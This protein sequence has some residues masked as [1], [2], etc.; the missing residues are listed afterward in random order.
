MAAKKK[1]AA[2]DTTAAPVKKAPAKKVAV[3]KVAAVK[4]AAVVR[5]KHADKPTSGQSG[6]SVVLKKEKLNEKEIKIVEVLA[7]DINP[8]PING[9]AAVAFPL[10]D[11]K[12]SNSWVRNSLR[13]LVRG[14]WVNKAA[15]G[16]YLLSETGT[17]LYSATA[18]AA[19]ASVSA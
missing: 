3:K 9:I 14:Q 15:K 17:A 18:P 8:M 5:K 16:T 11:P 7:S 12:Q 13:R 6:P 2:T 19:A 10:R 1:T 4:K